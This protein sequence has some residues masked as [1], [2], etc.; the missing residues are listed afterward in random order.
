LSFFVFLGLP[1]SFLVFHD[2]SNSLFGN[3]IPSFLPVDCSRPIV[4]GMQILSVSSHLNLQTHFLHRT[5]VLRRTDVFVSDQLIS[6]LWPEGCGSL[7]GI[8]VVELTHYPRRRSRNDTFSLFSSSLTL[9]L[10]PFFDNSPVSCNIP[11]QNILLVWVWVW[12]LVF[13]IVIGGFRIQGSGET[14]KMTFEF[15]QQPCF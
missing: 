5:D 4:S 2:P 3:E 7:I 10:P 6:L 1:L 9:L 15:G 13:V 12:V 11:T 14:P 8:P